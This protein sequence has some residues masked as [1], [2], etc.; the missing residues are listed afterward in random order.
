MNYVVKEIVVITKKPCTL[1]QNS[2]N[3]TPQGKALPTEGTKI[4]NSLEKKKP[5]DRHFGV[6]YWNMAEKGIVF[7]GSD[8]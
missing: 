7:T 5:K 6:L 1:F 4:T 2:K 3:Y 8:M